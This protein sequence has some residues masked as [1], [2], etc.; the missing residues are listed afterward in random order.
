M[1]DFAAV[2]L[3]GGAAQRMGGAAKPAL[4]VGGENMLSRV[5]AAAAAAAPRIV[6]GPL[7]L[8]SIL[9]TGVSLTIEDPPRAGPVAAINAGVT[10]LTPAVEWVAV[11]AGDLPFLR[12]DVLA[13]L[14]DLLR[15]QPT[16]ATGPSDAR[17]P[18][19]ATRPAEVAVLVDDTGRPQW[20]CSVWR[21]VVLAD[22]LARLG[23][24]NGRSMR[25]LTSGVELRQLTVAD[26]GHPPAW[27]DCD[28]DEDLR[29]AEEWARG[30][31][32]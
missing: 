5:L 4:P 21:R 18:S 26:P 27:F 29:Q 10:L 25:E 22:R 9:P 15:E 20:L 3:A 11:L 31:I 13:D 19:N 2:V 32:G 17:G 8:A 6:V 28:T 12:P 7:E 23:N 16:D 1:S 14:R 30:D 24:V